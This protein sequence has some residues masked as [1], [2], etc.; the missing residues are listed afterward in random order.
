LRELLITPSAQNRYSE[1]GFIQETSTDRTLAMSRGV[2][3]TAQFV[4]TMSRCHS[5]FWNCQRPCPCQN[6][7]RTRLSVSGLHFPRKPRMR[8]CYQLL[9][10]TAVTVVAIFA[11]FVRTLTCDHALPVSVV[12]LHVSVCFRLSAADVIYLYFI[13]LSSAL[14]RYFVG[15][16]RSFVGIFLVE[17]IH[18]SF[19]SIVSV[20][21][22]LGILDRIQVYQYSIPR[23]PFIL[24]HIK[25][26]VPILHI[27]SCHISYCVIPA[28]VD[29]TITVLVH[30]NVSPDPPNPSSSAIGSYV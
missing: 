10:L 16:H 11:L 15:V 30:W 27:G 17:V 4:T 22:P 5:R 7:D 18:W 13:G 8:N 28:L 9:L 23:Y 14:H 3:T 24:E 12:I 21:S 25:A 6:G 1:S 29:T 20:L 2:F 19:M 26:H